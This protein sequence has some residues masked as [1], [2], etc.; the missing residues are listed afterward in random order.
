MIL[1]IMFIP[2]YIL[3]FWK[4]NTRQVLDFFSFHTQYPPSP[5]EKTVTWDC[6]FIVTL[7][8]RVDKYFILQFLV[9]SILTWCYR[10]YRTFCFI[11]CISNNHLKHSLRSYGK[12]DIL[13][14]GV[15]TLLTPQNHCL[16]SYCFTDKIFGI[17][18]SMIVVM[19]LCFVT[20]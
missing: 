19:G 20:T 6:P 8:H 9:K 3:S 13:S 17:G 4:H 5:G 14:S 7:W 2:T 16:V 11:T 10:P 12:Q 1:D 15:Q 18:V